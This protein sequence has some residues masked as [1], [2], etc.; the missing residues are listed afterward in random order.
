MPL[1]GIYEKSAYHQGMNLYDR[2]KIVV[3]NVS[4]ILWLTI[5][6]DEL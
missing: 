3:V 6:K 1:S 4:T 2:L 5:Y